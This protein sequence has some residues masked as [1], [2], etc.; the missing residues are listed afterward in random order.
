MVRIFSISVPPFAI[1]IMRNAVKSLLSLI[2]SSFL[3]STMSSNSHFLR[4]VDFPFEICFSLVNMIKSPYIFIK[5]QIMQEI[6]QSPN[7]GIWSIPPNNN[8]LD[9][10]IT[11]IKNKTLEIIKSIVQDIGYLPVWQEVIQI[12]WLPDTQESFQYFIS[13]LTSEYIQESNTRQYSKGISRDVVATV[14]LIAS[15]IWFYSSSNTYDL[16]PLPVEDELHRLIGVATMSTAILSPL[17]KENHTDKD[18]DEFF[19][20]LEEFTR[21]E[22]EN[23]NDDS[24]E[25]YDEVFEFIGYDISRYYPSKIT[26]TLWFQILHRAS[27]EM[28]QVLMKIPISWPEHIISQNTTQ[29]IST[30]Y[31]RINKQNVHVVS[32]DR[33]IQ[34]KYKRLD[35]TVFRTIVDN[36]HKKYYRLMYNSATHKPYLYIANSITPWSGNLDEIFEKT[37][38]LS[39]AQAWTKWDI[40]S[41]PLSYPRIHRIYKLDENNWWGWVNP[42]KTKELEL[43]IISHLQT[44]INTTDTAMSTTVI[45]AAALVDPKFQSPTDRHRQVLQTLDCV[46]WTEDL[47]VWVRT[48]EEPWAEHYSNSRKSYDTLYVDK[49]RCIVDKLKE[50]LEK[51]KDAKVIINFIQNSP[52]VVVNLLDGK[53]TIFVSDI[54]NC[55][56]QVF[57]RTIDPDFLRSW[58]WEEPMTMQDLWG[59]FGPWT[60]VP[61]GTL[62]T[63]NEEST[64]KWITSISNALEKTPADYHLDLQWGLVVDKAKILRE[65]FTNN[66]L[67]DSVNSVWLFGSFLASYNKSL[68]INPLLTPLEKKE[69]ALL[70]AKWASMNVWEAISILG[71]NPY[72]LRYHWHNNIFKDYFTRLLRWDIVSAD[73]LF[74]EFRKNHVV[75]KA[76]RDYLKSQKVSMNRMTQQDF[77]E[78]FNGNSQ[79]K[80]A[81]RERY[82]IPHWLYTVVSWIISLWEDPTKNER[83]ETQEH[84]LMRILNNLNWFSKGAIE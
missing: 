11:E 51:N 56:T 48:W 2:V 19:W 16:P 13:L 20:K 47:I 61:T 10:K 84:Y 65:L 24:K 38:I 5:I 31:R 28:K 32:G 34:K 41:L 40:T 70:N 26:P 54:E 3:L 78:L 64:N 81:I 60:S 35:K 42:E 69:R 57:S 73:T 50:K 74:E 82:T 83:W 58:E 29:G 18:I 79:N 22:N 17:G 27:P 66:S 14:W 49:L 12:T 76:V 21:L 37:D 6:V 1:F 53:W 23:G 46:V 63:N 36:E 80:K 62:D 52:Y 71:G 67:G 8:H 4:M 72:F 33:N 15:K 45:N 43:Q 9:E 55:S 68:S 77:S 75:W 39:I 30:S 25:D 59:L 44:Q 7:G